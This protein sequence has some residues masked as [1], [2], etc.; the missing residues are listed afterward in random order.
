M[1]PILVPGLE[2]GPSETRKVAE[3]D[4][5]GSVLSVTYYQK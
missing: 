5:F 4:Q 2:E 3:I 1:G